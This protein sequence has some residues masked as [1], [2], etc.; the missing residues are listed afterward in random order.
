MAEPIATTNPSVDLPAANNPSLSSRRCFLSRAATGLAAG[1]VTAAAIGP[2]LAASAPANPLANS[3]GDLA[4][5]WGTDDPIIALAE[6]CIAL[7]QEHRAALTAC[8]PFEDLMFAWREA[9]PEP[10]PVGIGY[11]PNAALLTGRGRGWVDIETGEELTTEQALPPNPGPTKQE[12]EGALRKWRRRER[13]AERRTGYAQA[14]AIASDIGDKHVRALEQLE[15]ATPRTWAGLVAKARVCRI[16]KGDD[17]LSSNLVQ[18]IMA[19]A[20]EVAS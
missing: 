1:L 4:A 11:N 19:L 14:D 20:G 6:R 12:H 18:D 3:A 7:D 2:A 15:D 10:K 16:C 8:E 5:I 17:R 9:N 13:Y